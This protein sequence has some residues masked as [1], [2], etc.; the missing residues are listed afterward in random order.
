MPS[1]RVAFGLL[2]AIA[3]MAASTKAEE[4]VVTITGQS[5]FDEVVGASSFV[6]VEFYAPWC[7]HCKKLAPE[8]EKAATALKEEGS[9]IVLAK[10]DATDDSNKALAEKFGVRGYPTIKVFTDGDTSSPGDYEGPR[11]ADGIVKYVKKISGPAVIALSSAEEVAAFKEEQDVPVVAFFDTAEGDAFDAYGKTAKKLRNDYGFGY[12]TDASLLTSTGVYFSN[13]S[14]EVLCFCL[15]ANLQSECESC[16]AGSAVA[17][18]KL[19]KTSPVYT[20]DLS[21]MGTWVAD[22][23]K[24]A[25]ITFGDLGAQVALASLPCSSPVMRK[26]LSAAFGAGAPTKVI[27]VSGIEGEDAPLMEALLA[28]S[29]E[30]SD[31]TFMYADTTMQ[32]YDR[33][34]SHFGVAEDA[35][36]AFVINNDEGKWHLFNTEV[37]AL[38]GFIADFKA[39]KLE[40]TVKSAAIPS[41]PYEDDVR[42]VVAKQFDEIIFSGKDVLIEFYAPWCGHCKSL[43]PTY[44]KVAAKFKDNDKI[45]IAKMDA[46]ANDVPSSKFD[47]KGFPTIYFVKGDGEVISYDGARSEDGFYSFIKKHA[48]ASAG[49]HDEL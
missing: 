7:G 45:E 22:A 9:N 38:P 36:P 41:D 28:Q 34:I 39:G 2:A 18:N 32:L 16:A 40:K 31:M 25:I 8:Y 17:F 35:V 43:A 44:S 49:T 12:V 19:E 11:E 21:E 14:L 46:T 23:T 30:N 24:P 10:V 29:K 37:S 15:I 4:N 48:S 1:S 5:S 33:V 20:G 27:G 26:A 47:V 6:V 13:I 42:V 3:L